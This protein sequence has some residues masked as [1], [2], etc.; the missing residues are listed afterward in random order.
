MQD[1]GCPEPAAVV[2]I[3]ERILSL[4]AFSLIASTMEAEG[5]DDEVTL[6]GLAPLPA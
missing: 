4:R 3:M 6:M 1:V 5:P 2:A